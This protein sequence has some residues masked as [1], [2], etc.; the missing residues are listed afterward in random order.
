MDI[1]RGAARRLLSRIMRT[2]GAVSSRSVGYFFVDRA[3]CVWFLF[4]TGLAR[5]KQQQHQPQLLKE[6]W[7]GTSRQRFPSLLL[8]PRDILVL[9]MPKEVQFL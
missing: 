2:A 7:K 9:T 3:L 8:Q 6:F 1:A 5:V 4:Q